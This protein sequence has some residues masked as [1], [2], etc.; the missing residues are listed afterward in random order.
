MQRFYGVD[1]ADLWR[2]GL[3]VRRLAVLIAGLPPESA[4]SAAVAGRP[5]GWTV[6]AL[7]VAD[8]FHAVTGKPHPSRPGPSG[9]GSTASAAAARHKDLAARLAAQRARLAASAP[10]SEN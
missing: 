6:E 9:A 10:T 5:A 1:L 8:V 7:V 3:S 4:T 2:G